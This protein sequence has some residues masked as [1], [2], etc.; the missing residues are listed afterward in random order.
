MADN[1]ISVEH[2][3]SP[4]K[5]DVL[6]VEEWPIWTKEVSTFPWTYEEKEMCFILQGTAT[7]T[8]EGGEPVNVKRNDL[9][10]FPKGMS[11]TWDIT[12]NIRKHYKLGD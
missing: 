8:P 6:W 1:H 10:V 11:C 7:I 2:N 4:A 3:P 9:V 12:K 5:L